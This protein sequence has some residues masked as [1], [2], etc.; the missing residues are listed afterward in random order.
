MLAGGRLRGKAN[1]ASAVQ[2]PTPNKGE[3]HP[4]THA[5]AAQPPPPPHTQTNFHCA[6]HKQTFTVPPTPHKLSL[7]A[8]SPTTL[9]PCNCRVALYASLTRVG[10]EQEPV[11][12][13]QLPMPWHESAAK[14][15]LMASDVQA[16]DWQK[17]PTVQA[18]PSSQLLPSACKERIGLTKQCSTTKVA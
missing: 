11:D 14:Q 7:D 9:K 15:G 16:P 12:G 5:S 1:H 2:P 3:G 10:V 17:S 8:D 18:L 4:P 13:S 6:P